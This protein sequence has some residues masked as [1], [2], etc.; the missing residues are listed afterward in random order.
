MQNQESVLLVDDNEL[1]LSCLRRFFSKEFHHVVA[2][3]TG[4][5]AVRQAERHF[6]H[7]VVLDLHLPGIDGWE[8]LAHIRKH[9]PRTQVVIATSCT[10]VDIRQR[11]L[12]RGAFEFLEKPFEFDELKAIV[13][14]MLANCLWERKMLKPVEVRLERTHKG[15]TYNLTASDLFVLTS[16]SFDIGTTL[17]MTLHVPGEE[18]IPVTGRVVRM[19]QSD[20]GLLPALLESE[21]SGVKYGVGL[22]VVE[23]SAAYASLVNSLPCLPAGKTVH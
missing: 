21:E 12:H 16:V 3:C 18:P 13:S 17:N 19:I 20:C 2:V 15:I 14:R 6:F 1:V 11:A 8:V 5:E 4:E 10:D 9:S 7:I 22:H 23:Q